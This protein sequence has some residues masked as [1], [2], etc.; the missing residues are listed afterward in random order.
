MLRT[1]NLG[2]IDESLIGKKVKITGWIDV[3]REHGKV[4]FVDLR[5]RYGKVQ[6]VIIQK[7][8]DFEKVKKLTKES[9]ILIEGDVNRRPKGSENKELKS[10]DVEIFINKVDI[11]NNCP[12]LPFELDEKNVNEDLRLKYRFLDLRRTDLQKNL[13]FRHKFIKAFRDYFDKENFIE[14]ETPFLGKSTPEGARDYIVPSRVNAG[15]FYALPQSPQLYKQLLMVSG[16]DKYLQI[17]RCMRDE[18]LRADRQP[19]F[20]QVDAEMSF[21]EEEDIYAVVE[22]SLKYVFKEVL[23]I[24][25]KTPFK[26][27][28]YDESMKKYNSDKPDL[29]PETKEKYAFTWIVDFPMFEYSKEDKKI[30]AAHHPFCMPSDP[31]KLEKDPLKIRARTFD[32][33]LNGTEL[34]SGSIRIHD[35]EIQKR[36]FKVLGI[37]EKEAEEKFGFLL[38]ALSYGAPVHGGFAIGLDRLIQI[39]TDSSSIREV[40]A[41]PKNQSAQDVMLSAPAEIDLKQLKEAHISVIEEKKKDEKKTEE[42]KIENKGKKEVKKKK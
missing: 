14:V 20:T 25:L 32:L 40:I 5:D 37:N 10:G 18:D 15:K 30:V 1:H 42:G 2:E 6:C 11:L 29:R 17:A 35:P 26:R 16:F 21:V 8:P 7:N 4:I 28:P 3:S 27:I 19:E 36:V 22:N 13:M 33:V 39:L 31:S 12:A 38:R 23:N 24:N 9:C 34:L 41:F